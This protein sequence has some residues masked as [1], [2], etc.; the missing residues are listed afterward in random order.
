MSKSRKRSDVR[1]TAP[2]GDFDPNGAWERP[3][4]MCLARLDN[5]AGA[6]NVG[7]LRLQRIPA[8]PAA[9]HFILVVEQ[10]A[11]MGGASQQTKAEIVCHNDALASLQS[12]KLDS[13][14]VGLDGKPREE[15][16]VREAMDALGDGVFRL[17]QESLR[18][19]AI[20]GRNSAP[21]TCNWSLMEAVQRLQRL[22]PGEA[23][24]PSFD[25]LE[26]LDALRTNQTITLCGEIEAILGGAKVPLIGYVQMGEGLQ[27]THYWLDK[28]RR[29]LIVAGGNRALILRNGGEGSK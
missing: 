9:D 29:L 28:Q 4:V 27:P 14:T 7:T 12:W 15:T 16:R 8:V 10:S 21:P 23:P 6:A 13:V 20:R 11:R 1:E 24:P 19:K 17:G 3:Y 5:P 2:S 22:P 18:R 26:D 25:M